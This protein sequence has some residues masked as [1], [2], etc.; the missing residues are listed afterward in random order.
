[1][2]EEQVVKEEV[3]NV[4][5]VQVVKKVTMF[6]DA[7]DT[8]HPHYIEITKVFERIRTGKSSKE[9]IEKL[10]TLNDK[11]EEAKLKKHYRLFVLLDCLLTALM[12]VFKNI[13]DIYAWILTILMHDFLW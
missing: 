2:S 4:E 3:K 11:D 9:I 5:E 10:R 6:K 7:Y 13:Q 8:S 1:M 12:R